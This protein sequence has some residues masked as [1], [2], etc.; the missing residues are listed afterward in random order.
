MET[1]WSKRLAPAPAEASRVVSERGDSLSPITAP[2]RMQPQT[3]GMGIPR[4]V[5]TP[6]SATPMVPA[7]PQLVPVA[8]EVITQMISVTGRNTAGWIS[9][10]P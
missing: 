10:K 4:P 8:R 9:F 1:I 7:V 6:I 2:E 5:A 3:S